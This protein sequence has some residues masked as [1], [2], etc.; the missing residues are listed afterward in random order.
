MAKAFQCDL[1]DHLSEGEPDQSI[2]VSPRH[3]GSTQLQMCSQCL[4]SF[5]DWRVSRA[6]NHDKPKVN[7]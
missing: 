4:A 6:P 7:A 5:N 2:N 3:G 1:C